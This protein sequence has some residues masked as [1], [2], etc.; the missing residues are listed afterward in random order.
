M[1][2][3]FSKNE[4]I[5]IRFTSELKNFGAHFVFLAKHCFI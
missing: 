1:G 2:L 5:H 4:L 3:I